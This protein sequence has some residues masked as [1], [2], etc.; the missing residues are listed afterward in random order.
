VCVAERA[1]GTDPL[2]CAAAGDADGFFAANPEWDV[3]IGAHGAAAVVM[4][5]GARRFDDADVAGRALLD[6][7]ECETPGAPLPMLVGGFAFHDDHAGEGWWRDFPALRL[8]LPTELVIRQAG[9]TW[10]LRIRRVGGLPIADTP[11]GPIEAPGDPTDDWKARVRSTLDDIDAGHLDKLVLAR[12]RDVSLVRRDP[13]ALVR[14][15]RHERP[16]C[17]TFLVRRGDVTFIGSTP[18][19]LVGVDRGRVE[20]VALAGSLRPEQ[21]EPDASAAARLLACSKNAA[22]HAFVADTIAA[23]LATACEDVETVEARAVRAFPEALHLAT[24]YRSRL[25][26]GMDVLRLVGRLHPT[27]AV[28]GVPRREAQARLADA[29]P[30]RGW[31]AGGIGW[32]D[33][34]GE[35]RFAVA[36]R[37]ALVWGERAR[38]WA[39]AG[40]VT[41]SD[42][43][44]E[45]EETEAKMSAMLRALEERARAA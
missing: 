24:S 16:T 21:G 20:T 13:I 22:E 28:A 19:A 9:A 23:E 35:G 12:S 2:D 30:H 40:I 44:A 39:G 5:T 25:A 45:W 42:P 7:V 6:L 32:L 26:A 29:E 3:E 43:E 31:Y 33:S 4:A 15:L 10:R 38:V 8:V 18:E 37:C 34:A 27:P 1:D 14:G 11:D 36:L 41:G 17:T